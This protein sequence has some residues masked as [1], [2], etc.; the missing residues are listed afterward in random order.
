MSNV[1]VIIV[2]IAL[3]RN[4]LVLPIGIIMIILD[5]LLT[6]IFISYKDKKSIVEYTKR[7]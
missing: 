7:G 2:S 5:A 3:F 4:W 1:G 6:S